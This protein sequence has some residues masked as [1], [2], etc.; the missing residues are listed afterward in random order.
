[1]ERGHVCM[2][3]MH[4]ERYNGKRICHGMGQVLG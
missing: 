4:G 1:M 2:H 3:A